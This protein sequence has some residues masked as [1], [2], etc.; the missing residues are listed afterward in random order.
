MDVWSSETA[1]SWM[2]PRSRG[3]VA[4][5]ALG[6]AVMAVYAVLGMIA[7]TAPTAI[8]VPSFGSLVRA[9]AG[10]F[11]ALFQTSRP[12]PAPRRPRPPR[13][14]CPP[15]PHAPSPSHARAARAPGP[16]DPLR[17]VPAPP[18]RRRRAPSPAP[19]TQ[20]DRVDLLDVPH[21]PG[22]L[23]ALR[24]H[25]AGGGRQRHLAELAG[26][27]PHLADRLALD[28]RERHHGP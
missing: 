8:T 15:H 22:A 7:L 6:A 4:A 21:D 24:L 5:V 27:A 25:H 11:T 10:S 26:H 20:L 23:R 19:P 12:A 28:G 3:M 17:R 13:R 1:G 16:H 18:P 2:V 9:D 14:P